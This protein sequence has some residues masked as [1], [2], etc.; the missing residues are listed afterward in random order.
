MSLQH[1]TAPTTF[2]GY[3]HS[4]KLKD[5]ITQPVRNELSQVPST[6]VPLLLDTKSFRSCQLRRFE[7]GYCTIKKGR[8]PSAEGVAA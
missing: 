7:E 6:P 4:T 5:T 1:Q 8:C 2:T 3:T